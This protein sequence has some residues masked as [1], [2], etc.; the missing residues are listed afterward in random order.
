VQTKAE[1]NLSDSTEHSLFPHL[2]QRYIF[3]PTKYL[4]RTYFIRQKLNSQ[5]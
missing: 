4:Y 5:K 1:T 3:I 2:V